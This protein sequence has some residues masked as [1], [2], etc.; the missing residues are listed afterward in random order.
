MATRDAFKTNL[1]ALARR[2]TVA[3]C[4]ERHVGAVQSFCEREIVGYKLHG[5]LHKLCERSRRLRLIFMLCRS[6]RRRL[7]LVKPALRW[8]SSVHAHESLRSP[9]W[10]QVKGAARLQIVALAWQPIFSRSPF[11][12]K[13]GEIA[14]R[15]NVQ[16]RARQTF[17]HSMAENTNSRTGDKNRVVAVGAVGGGIARLELGAVGRQTCAQ[18]KSFAFGIHTKIA[19]QFRIEHDSRR[20]GRWRASQSSRS[21]RSSSRVVSMQRIRRLRQPTPQ[22][23]LKLRPQRRS[24]RAAAYLQAAQSS[25]RH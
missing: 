25:T 1:R 11:A 16:I 7:K 6:T 10:G 3:S 13:L 2:I 4:A 18:A 24:A 8:P 17:V 9:L 19:S 21:T 20:V 22:L 14:G 12:V 15:V 5:A 23:A